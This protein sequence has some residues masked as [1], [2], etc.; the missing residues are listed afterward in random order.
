MSDPSIHPTSSEA[1]PAPDLGVIRVARSNTS[2]LGWS[3]EEGL[4]PVEDPTPVG[5]LIYLALILLL[6]RVFQTGFGEWDG[7]QSGVAAHNDTVVTTSL[8]ISGTH[9]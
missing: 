9:W 7:L 5:E 1:P 2:D 8:W 3:T 6:I 4:D